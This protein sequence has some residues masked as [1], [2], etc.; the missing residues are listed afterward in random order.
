M[1][2]RDF[3]EITRFL[4]LVGKANLFEYF[5]LES[6]V[7]AEQ[8]LAA[9]RERR[10][11]AQGQQANPKY[12][13]EALW[14]IKHQRL[15]RQA[16]ADERDAYLAEVRRRDEDRNL[17]VLSLFIMGTLADGALTP[18]REEAIRAHG[19]QLGL[20]D[21]LI[22]RRIDEMLEEHHAVRTEDDTS[23]EV[24]RD[25]YAAL[26][27]R[28]DATQ[29]EIEQA[30]RARYRWARSLRDT[31]KASEVYARLDAAWRILKDPDKRA[32]YD[33][34]RRALTNQ[35]PIESPPRGYPGAKAEPRPKQA[36]PV[37]RDTPSPQ[38]PKPPLSA[39]PRFEPVR[40]ARHEPAVKT[41]GEQTPDPAR[42][43]V[44]N[45]VPP[46]HRPASPPPPPDDLT[47]M[48]MGMTGSG[49]QPPG[50]LSQIEI[51]GP[52][53][54]RVRVWRNPRTCTITVRH[55]G[56]P[57]F[58]SKVFSDREWVRVSPAVLDRQS[59]EQQVEIEILPDRMSRRKAVAL[60][61][62]V[63]DRGSRRS[64]TIEVERIRVWAWAAGLV[65]VV[66]L[67]IG[68]PRLVPPLVHTLVDSIG[69]QATESG[70]KLVVHADPPG[71]RIFVNGKLVGPTDIDR[72][73]VLQEGFPVGEPFTLQAELNGFRTISQ[74]VTVPKDGTVEVNARLDLV[75]PL[76]YTPKPGDTQGELD[77]EVI[78]RLLSKRAGRF[79]RCFEQGLTD[80]KPGFQAKTRIRAFVG[81]RGYVEGVQ[82]NDKNYYS[83][84]VDDCLARELRA[85]HF[86]PVKGDYAV[87]ERMLEHELA[88]RTTAEA[89][90]KTA[91]GGTE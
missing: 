78:E 69:R 24:I 90:N 49:D 32:R 17:E 70:P 66:A 54:R 14:V 82:F 67:V 1:D 76:D 40:P 74:Q 89:A 91:G 48:S 85:I 46:V 77:A 3:D 2:Q 45:S 84:E 53:D 73:L 38:V 64:V 59:R 51:D 31:R 68:G 88:H 36:P 13:E 15:L 80:S 18:R 52:T 39:A 63:G 81:S 7:P 71:A 86:P 22:S 25:H 72:P 43:L 11:W 10:S 33:E 41:P 47:A 29:E 42:R 61:T 30:Y 12:R 35:S 57:P 34:Q 65:A 20:T 87:F 79:D 23:E 8:A 5:G 16:L 55:N 27:V 37:H 6:D 60:V 26:H 44:S 28:P 83:E 56:R 62:V 50:G 58:H 21:E 4:T 9:I 19:R 75:K